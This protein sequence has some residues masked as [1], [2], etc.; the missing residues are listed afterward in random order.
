MISNASRLSVGSV[1]SLMVAKDWTLGTWGTLKSS[2]RLPDAL[3]KTWEETRS[4]SLLP[5]SAPR[6]RTSPSEQMMLTFRAVGS[7]ILVDT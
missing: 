6:S 7:S 3:L 2:E 5:C 4:R 1:T